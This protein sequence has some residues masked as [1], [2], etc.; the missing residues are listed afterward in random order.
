VQ[1]C[2][3]IVTLNLTINNSVFG[4]DIQTACE[5]FTW[6][7]GITYNVS[8][9]TPTFIIVGGSAQGTDSIVTLNLTIFNAVNVIDIQSACDSYTWIDGI[10]YTSSNSVAVYTIAAGSYNGCDSIITLN[11]T[12]NNTYNS[13]ITAQICSGQ[14][15]I[16]P[17]GTSTNIGGIFSYNLVSISGCDSIL[18]ITLNVLSASTDTINAQ[19]CNGQPYLLPNGTIVNT[20]GIYDVLFTNQYGCDSTVTTVI[21]LGANMLANVQIACTPSGA[22]CAGTPVTYTAGSINGGTAPTYQWFVNG[23]AVS[24]QTMNEFTSFNLNDRC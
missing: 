2:D 17:D 1:G 18:Q 13:N 4:V 7:D 14:S 12:I 20:N 19:I 24:G 16:L 6:I 9:N 3:S 8:T 10:T 5:S 15:F 11:L 22:I 23:I 21:T